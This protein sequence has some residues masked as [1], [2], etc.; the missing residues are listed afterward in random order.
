MHTDTDGN[1]IFPAMKGGVY[2]SAVFFL[3]LLCA[4]LLGIFL[5]RS[6]TGSGVPWLYVMMATIF[7]LID[8][9]IIAL[10]RFSY[11]L[12]EK[13][14]KLSWQVFL[15]LVIQDSVPYAKIIKFY[16]TDDLLEAASQVTSIRMINIEFWNNSGKKDKISVS[17][18][19]RERFVSELTERTG[20]PLSEDLRA[21]K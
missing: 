16:K 13:G 14:I 6:F 20:I 10:S 21:K 17:P 7:L 12:D 1:M 3:F 2:Y 5:Y 11:V 15:S 8:I 9:L 4:V 18:A 19:D